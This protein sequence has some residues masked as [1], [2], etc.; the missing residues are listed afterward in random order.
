MREAFAFRRPTGDGVLDPNRGL[1]SSAL[2]LCLDSLPELFSYPRAFRHA[3]NIFDAVLF[4][5]CVG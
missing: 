1:L 5:S 2:V 4:V 3:E